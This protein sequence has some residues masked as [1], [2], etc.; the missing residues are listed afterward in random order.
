MPKNK[1]GFL[2]DDSLM[3]AY[4]LFTEEQSKKI[5][6]LLSAG[7][8][9]E[10]EEMITDILSQAD[11]GDLAAPAGPTVVYL[12]GTKEVQSVV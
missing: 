7:K 1:N 3:G 5:Q 6:E 2:L 11:I 9:D 4:P 10:A 8:D 12:D